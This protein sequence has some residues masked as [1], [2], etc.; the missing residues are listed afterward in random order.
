MEIASLYFD[1]VQEIENKNLEKAEV[2]FKKII[3]NADLGY[4]VLSYFKLANINFNKKISN[5][6]KVIMIKLLA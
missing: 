1:G 6:W 2:I 3:E 5:P 4:T